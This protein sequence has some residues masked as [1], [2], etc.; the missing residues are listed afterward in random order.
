MREKEREGNYSNTLGRQAI[1]LLDSQGSSRVRTHLSGPLTSLA[2]SFPLWIPEA[3]DCPQGAQ[4]TF[5]LS[6]N[7]K[8]TTVVENGK[9]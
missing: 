8:K 4:I 7:T 6:L 2:S 1:G 3:L 9:R 5:I